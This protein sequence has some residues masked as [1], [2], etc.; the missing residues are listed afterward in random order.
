MKNY[1]F[2]T[3]EGVTGNGKLKCTY[4]GK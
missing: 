4:G 3:E 1:I 2:I